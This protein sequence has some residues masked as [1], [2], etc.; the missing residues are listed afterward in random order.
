MRSAVLVCVLAASTAAALHLKDNESPPADYSFAHYVEDFGTDKQY[1]AFA[2]A[3]KRAATFAKNL[4]L[5]RSHNSKESTWKAGVNE[6]T[7]WTVEEVGV[8]SRCS[9]AC[10]SEKKKKN[11]VR[12]ALTRH[13]LPAYCGANCCFASFLTCVL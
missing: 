10:R 13:A 9:V 1:F 3:S 6:F 7:D 5:I 4:E 8:T 12:T 11:F 2:E